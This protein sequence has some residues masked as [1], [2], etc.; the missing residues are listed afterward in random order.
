M[1]RSRVVGREQFDDGAGGDRFA[2][3]LGALGE[4]TPGRTAVTP[5]G[6]PAGRG[7]P[8]VGAAEQR[9]GRTQAAGDWVAAPPMPSAFTAARATST[10]A[11][12][13]ASSVTAS[14]A[15]TLRSTSTSARRRPWMNRL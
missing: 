14:S 10:S 8:G 3:C 1:A 9:I 15:S 2:D 5:A 13:A 7:E 6:E 4:K 11:A 12:K